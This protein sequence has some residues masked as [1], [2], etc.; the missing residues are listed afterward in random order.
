MIASYNA[1]AVREK[2]TSGIWVTTK[3][4][5]VAVAN[6]KGKMKPFNYIVSYKNYRQSVSDVIIFDDEEII[7]EPIGLN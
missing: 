1:T 6:R 7:E 3:V 4:D 5:T 2:L